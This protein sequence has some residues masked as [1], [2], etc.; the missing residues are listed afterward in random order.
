MQ[1]NN[2]KLKQIFNKKLIMIEKQIVTMKEKEGEK[3]KTV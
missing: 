3:S 2:I 1:E